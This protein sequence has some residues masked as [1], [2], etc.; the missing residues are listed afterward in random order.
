MPKLLSKVSSLCQSGGLYTSI[1]GVS[2]STRVD[3]DESLWKIE[4]ETR[5][6]NRKKKKIM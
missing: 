5:T 3:I 1:P 4:K 2:I 6:K